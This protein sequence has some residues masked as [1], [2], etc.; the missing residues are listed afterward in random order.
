MSKQIV[1]QNIQLCNVL[2]RILARLKASKTIADKADLRQI[3][4][5]RIEEIETEEEVFRNRLYIRKYLKE[6]LNREQ[7]PPRKVPKPVIQEKPAAILPLTKQPVCELSYY[8]QFKAE[9]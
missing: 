9:K 3:Y 8:A 4:M 2:I 5:E 6:L 1:H 7:P